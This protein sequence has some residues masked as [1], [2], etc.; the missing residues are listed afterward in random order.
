MLATR[1]YQ[2]KKMDEKADSMQKAVNSFIASVHRCL[3]HCHVVWAAQ[4]GLSVNLIDPAAVATATA[5]PC[6]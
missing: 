1:R 3:Q 4:Q 2:L 6:S 5:Q